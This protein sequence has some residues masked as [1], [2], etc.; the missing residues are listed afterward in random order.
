[1]VRKEEGTEMSEKEKISMLEETLG[2]DEGSLNPDIVLADLDE[3]DSMA[4]LALIVMFDDEF[5][6][7]MTGTIIKGFKTV[8]DIMALMER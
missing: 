6:K 8:S 2:M 1:M 3:Y 7:K 5:E 4:K